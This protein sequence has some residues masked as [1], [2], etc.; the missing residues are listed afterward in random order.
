VEPDRRGLL[1]FALAAMS[2]TAT[3]IL[4]GCSEEKPAIKNVCGDSSWSGG[5]NIDSEA[6]VLAWASASWFW[7]AHGLRR[8]CVPLQSK[9]GTWD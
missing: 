7:R 3:I 5:I 6:D 9:V 8:F 1:V 4:P 2:A